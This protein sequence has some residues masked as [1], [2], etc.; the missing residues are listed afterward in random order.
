MP[1]VGFQLVFSKSME[2]KWI[3]YP[4]TF[5]ELLETFIAHTVAVGTDNFWTP[6]YHNGQ[7]RSLSTHGL[8]LTVQDRA[9]VTA[10]DGKAKTIDNL[11][12]YAE[13]FLIDIL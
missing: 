8:Y 1:G 4:N 13:D 5:R 11:R 7:M 2:S 12:V 3:R 6:W 9:G 10:P